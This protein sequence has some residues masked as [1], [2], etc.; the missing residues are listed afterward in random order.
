LFAYLLT[1]PSLEKRYKVYSKT[2]RFKEEFSGYALNLGLTSKDELL[3]WGREFHGC[4]SVADN[5]LIAK[6]IALFQNR[7]GLFWLNSN[8]TF[9]KLPIHFLW[10]V[11]TKTLDNFFE[12]GFTTIGSLQQIP[13]ESLESRLGEEGIQIYNYCRGKYNTQIPP[14]P[15][16]F[17]KVFHEKDLNQVLF[18]LKKELPRHATNIWFASEKKSIELC[19]DK[20]GRKSLTLALEALFP[21]ENLTCLIWE[22]PR[23]HQKS[24]FDFSFPSVIQ[25]LLDQERSLTLGISVSRR[26]RVRSS[27]FIWG[28]G[29]GSHLGKTNSN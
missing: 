1:S 7:P 3:K 8:A 12:T 27:N 18:F 24:L 22:E 21:W 17:E 9:Y 23:A 6:A 26:E 16:F 15:P 5:L 29:C 13:L 20:I 14:S 28:Y 11:A 4:L 19:Q 10:P 25:E 2:P